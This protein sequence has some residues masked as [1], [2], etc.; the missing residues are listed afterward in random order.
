MDYLRA[1]REFELEL[2][3]GNVDIRVNLAIIGP[4]DYEI[5]WM[6]LKK[7]EHPAYAISSFLHHLVAIF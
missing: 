5:W 2:S 3:S 6:T 7:I 4:C 1:I